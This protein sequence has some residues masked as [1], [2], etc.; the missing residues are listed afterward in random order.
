MRLSD[1]INK[2]RSFNFIVM[3][4]LPLG[5]TLVIYFQEVKSELATINGTKS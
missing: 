3:S 2:H 4:T 1:Y 5:L